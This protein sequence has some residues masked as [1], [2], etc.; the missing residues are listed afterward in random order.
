MWLV[1]S[2]MAQATMR[3]MW[4][5]ERASF[6]VDVNLAK[7]LDNPKI[8]IGHFISARNLPISV[9]TIVFDEPYRLRRND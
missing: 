9:S 8:R 4:K 3:H 5:F 1:V 2:L 7:T 6:L